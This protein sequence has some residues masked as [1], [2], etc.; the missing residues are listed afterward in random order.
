MA[1]FFSL[2]SQLTMEMIQHQRMALNSK[3]NIKGMGKKVLRCV[4]QEALYALA[5]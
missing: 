1:I 2:E 5:R 4:K 3:R